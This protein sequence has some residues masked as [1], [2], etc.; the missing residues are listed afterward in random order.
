M[1]KYLL[2]LLFLVSTTASAEVVVDT[3]IM[4]HDDDSMSPTHMMPYAASNNAT[5]HAHHKLLLPQM[6]PHCDTPKTM[7]LWYNEVANQSRVEHHSVVSCVKEL[8]KLG[9]PENVSR[10]ACGAP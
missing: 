3:M 8:R 4:M 5:R 2:V 1:M 6:P 7:D 9:A 10:T